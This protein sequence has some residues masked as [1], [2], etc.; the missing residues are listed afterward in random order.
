MGVVGAFKRM[1]SVV[2]DLMTGGLLIKQTPP[3]VYGNPLAGDESLPDKIKPLAVQE[4]SLI[5]TERF[6]VQDFQEPYCEIKGGKLLICGKGKMQMYLKDEMVATI[7][8]KTNQTDNT[9][10]YDV[11]RGDSEDKIGH[12]KKTMYSEGDDF[13]FQFIATTGSPEDTET[14][15]EVAYQ[16]EGDFLAR[17]FVMKNMKKE[18][19]AK[20]T[21]RLIAFAA[22]DHYVIRIAVGMDPMLVLACMV[23]IDD[24]LDEKLKAT[25]LEA[26]PRFFLLS[27][28]SI[29]WRKKI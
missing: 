26:P 22:F 18:C 1:A 12:I 24:V 7:I 28:H 23:V 9:T 29:K 13:Y 14:P 17:R 2:G 3:F 5:F 16:L 19:V 11:V 15:S 21:K 8:K 25:I 20:V 27:I 10:Y 4:R 6:C